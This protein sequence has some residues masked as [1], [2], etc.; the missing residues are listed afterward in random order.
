MQTTTI[1]ITVDKSHLIVIG[2]RLYS[3]SLELIRELVSNAYDAD[4]T[5]IWIEVTPYTLTV[6]D[7]G[8]G[9]DLAGLKQYFNIGSPEKRFN[10]KSPLFNRTRIGEFGIGKFAALS[11][12]DVFTIHTQKEAFAA[13]LTF[14]KNLWSAVEEWEIPIEIETCNPARGDGTTITLGPLKKQLTI[15]DIE[16]FLKERI[17]LKAPN[18]NVYLNGKQITASVVPGKKFPIQRQ[19][20]YGVIRGEIIIPNFP[21]IGGKEALPGIECFV[22]EVFIKRELFGFEHSHLFTASRIRG[23]IHGDFL[24][25]TSDRSRFITD[26]PAYEEFVRLMRFEIQLILRQLKEHVNIRE[27]KK[28]DTVLRD[29]LSHIRRALKK[30]PEFAPETKIPTADGEKQETDLFTQEREQA[31]EET[32]EQN[33]ET[34]EKTGE[35]AILHAETGGAGFREPSGE[36]IPAA[37]K[38]TDRS[39]KRVRV[40]TLTGKEFVARSMK[41]GSFSIVCKC[42]QLGE[43]SPPVVSET[44]IIFINRDHPLYKRFSKN[45]EAL[46]LFVTELIAQEIA[47]NRTM[48]AQEAF[49]LQNQILTDAWA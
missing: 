3:Q 19:T 11:A 41:L 5:H 47:R 24:P 49:M 32:K 10:K 37:K 38:Q 9:M 16:R 27:E 36:N 17:P 7:N 43:N 4:A 31:R 21:P 13:K 6:K 20:A 15:P 1:P 22:N 14:D 25:I 44:G 26:S 2:E 40:K 30:N 46:T 29:A 18:F 48:A 12:C 42:H 39:S 35:T 33:N 8:S 23:E 45:A 28:A 34:L